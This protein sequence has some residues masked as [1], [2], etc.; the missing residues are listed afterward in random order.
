MNAPTLATATPAADPDVHYGASPADHQFDMAGAFLAVSNVCAD[1]RLRPVS[2]EVVRMYRRTQVS[3]Q[4]IDG[5]IAAVNA[6]ADH[7]GLPRHDG[8]VGTVY[9]RTGRCLVVGHRLMVTAF[10]GRTPV[11]AV[12]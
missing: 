3:V 10:A 11:A 6:L 7:L 9:D 12:A 8:R 4:L 1:L 2:V 5:G